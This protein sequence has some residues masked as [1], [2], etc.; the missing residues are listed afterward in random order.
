MNFVQEQLKMVPMK[1]LVA[2]QFM[3]EQM[4]TKY[5]LGAGFGLSRMSQEKIAVQGKRALTKVFGSHQKGRL[6]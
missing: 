3:R 2:H 4:I 6:G 1:T 5:C